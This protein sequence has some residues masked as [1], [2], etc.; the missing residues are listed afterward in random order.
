MPRKPTSAA[1]AAEQSRLLPD[2]S[3]DKAQIEQGPRTLP[4][5]S[6]ERDA[7]SRGM[8]V[9][10]GVDEVGRGAL[11]GPV[12]AAAVL[13]DPEH[14]PEG[15]DDSKRLTARRRDELAEQIVATAL[16]WR[17]ARVEP[18]EID[19]INILRASLAAMRIALEEMVPQADHVLVDGHMSIPDWFG[20]Q[21]AVIGGDGISASIAAA[22]IVAKVTRDK[23]MRDYD[24]AWPGYGFAS[25]V[26]YA[27]RAHR[28]AIE[29]LGPC[30]LHRR[31]FRG[32][33]TGDLFAL[34][35][36]PSD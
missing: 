28:E 4:D 29:R 34:L 22:S 30:P 12:V 18:D 27:T 6:H 13:L 5:M 23:L 25:H 10:A 31:S 33:E 3:P 15:L 14:V 19:R 11:A 21:A 1:P 20:S 17:V 9:V 32:C 35:E 7:W 24:E 16:C 36:A 8:R 2:A 26:G